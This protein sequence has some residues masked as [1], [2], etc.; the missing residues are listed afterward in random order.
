[1]PS[2]GTSSCVKR[3]A[4]EKSQILTLSAGS[5]Y[6]SVRIPIYS[7]VYLSIYRLI[8]QSLTLSGC[9][10]LFGTNTKKTFQILVNTLRLD[11][12]KSITHVIAPQVVQVYGS[13]L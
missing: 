1:M 10:L 6:L 9:Q 7:P 2:R 8:D 12:E 13:N 5:I 3:G 11:A 4:G